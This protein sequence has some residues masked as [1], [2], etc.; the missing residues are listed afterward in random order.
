MI[1]DN[2]DDIDKLIERVERNLAYHIDTDVYLP[3]KEELR[4]KAEH[5]LGIRK[6]L[7]KKFVASEL[8]T[9]KI[10]LKKSIYEKS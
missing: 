4:G 3:I 1:S 2:D 10:E 6:E 9:L 8:E 5:S 7:F